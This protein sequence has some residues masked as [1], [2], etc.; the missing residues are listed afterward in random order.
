MATNERAIK[1]IVLLCSNSFL[2]YIDLAYCIV[3]FNEARNRITYSMLLSQTLINAGQSAT[4]KWTFCCIVIYLGD[5]VWCNYNV[6]WCIWRLTLHFELYVCSLFVC[7]GSCDKHV[8][9]I[10]A[11]NLVTVSFYTF[12]I[13]VQ[14]IVYIIWFDDNVYNHDLTSYEN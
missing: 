2:L 13:D 5:C 10:N 4:H 12:K 3:I 6:Y 1:I 8:K 14:T 7:T 9:I 11:P